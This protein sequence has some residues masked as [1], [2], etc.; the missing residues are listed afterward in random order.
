MIP[1][2]LASEIDIDGKPRPSGDYDIGAYE[3]QW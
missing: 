2:E 3:Y 1:H